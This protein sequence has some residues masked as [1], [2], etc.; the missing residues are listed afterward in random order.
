MSRGIPV[1]VKQ[2]DIGGV[3]VREIEKF[4]ENL[5]IRQVPWETE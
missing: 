5:R 2:L 4:P 3:C 1:F